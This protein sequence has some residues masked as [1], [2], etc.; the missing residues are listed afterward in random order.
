LKLSNTGID[1]DAER[2][3]GERWNLNGNCEFRA[4]IASACAFVNEYRLAQSLDG[5]PTAVRTESCEKQAAIW[6]SALPRAWFT[7]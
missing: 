4:R 1:N 5:K 3:S 7:R 2:A 6:P